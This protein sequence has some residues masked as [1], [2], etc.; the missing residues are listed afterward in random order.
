MLDFEVFEVYTEML[1]YL[2]EATSCK[3][4]VRNLTTSV[5]QVF[6]ELTDNDMTIF[7]VFETDKLL[8]LLISGM[9]LKPSQ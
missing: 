2:V 3:K 7:K 6:T 8:D 4:Y 1:I 5:L 9:I